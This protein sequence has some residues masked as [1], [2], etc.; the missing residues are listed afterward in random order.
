MDEIINTK[1]QIYEQHRYPPDPGAMNYRVVMTTCYTE[2][3]VM[4]PRSES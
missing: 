1:L 4:R 3:M 2:Y